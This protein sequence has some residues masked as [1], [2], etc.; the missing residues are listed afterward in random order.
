[1]AVL[2]LISD[3]KAIGFVLPWASAFARARFTSLT[4]VCWTHSPVVVAEGS[5]P[6]SEDLVQA[7]HDFLKRTGAAEEPEVIGVSGPSDSAAAVSM[8]R[9]MAAELIV[10]A[11]NDPTGA[12]GATYSTNLLLKQSPCNTIVLF[13]DSKRSIEPR[14]IF[15][16]STDNIHDEAAIF[17]ASGLA[18]SQDAR[19]T[20]ARAE[21]DTEQMGREV[22]R[23][24]LQHLIRDAGIDN[25][26]RIDCHV[27][28]TGD[29]EEV[30]AAMEEHD[31]VLLGA[32]CPLV[33]TIIGLTKKPTV[34]VIQRAPPLRP[35]RTAKRSAHWKQRLSPADYAELIQSLRHGSRLGAD[36]V[37]ML[38]L[39]TIVA[40]M[41]LLQD[42][43]AVVIGSMLLAPLMTPMIGCGL[44]LAQAN[45]KLG[46]TALGTVAAGLLCTLAIS[47]L[48]GLITP[49][50]ELTP[51]IYARGEPTVLDLV[52]AVASA[53]AAAYALARPNL[54]GSIA[55][56]AIATALVP[57]LCSVGLS[58]AYGDMTN[59]RGAALLFVIN[60]LAIV[61]SAAV[62]FRLI[63]I[64]AERA[65]SREKFWVFRT[66]GILGIAALLACYPLQRELFESLVERKPQPRAFPLAKTVMDA[67]ENCVEAEPGVKLI[68]AGR[69]SSHFVV[70]DV[71]LILGATGELDSS[72]AD[73]LV[74]I[75]KEK[76]Q[77]E[78][79]VVE[80]HCV[81][82]LWQ[83]TS[84]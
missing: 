44:A 38:S 36:F 12:E 28:R 65:G 58:L 51:Q 66:A 80:V 62:T 6:V 77:D 15:V 57:P 47:F 41:G 73:E 79:L 49:G 1:M 54:V 34:A 20:L 81:K 32:N 64:T 25:A 17:L 2:A 43:P 69:P 42:S 50:A 39:A 61:L 67:L 26:G 24:E 31:L 48:V 14:R 3:E 78:S 75:V 53:A 9:Q 72:F 63:G 74:K 8:A 52:V 45:R 68:T 16:G 40:S 82:E 22:A 59:A 46:N 84:K 60:F 23:R 5:E 70:S 29:Y 55:G 76:M 18:D 4:V 11:A 56:V 13:G 19:I 7:A 30:A 35:W 37:T 83:E 27:F 10:T 71:V 33:P 21:L